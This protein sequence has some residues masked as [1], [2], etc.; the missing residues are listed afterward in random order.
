LL[1]DDWVQR[2]VT[3]NPVGHPSPKT[4]MKWWDRMSQVIWAIWIEDRDIVWRSGIGGHH[5][6]S[7]SLTRGWGRHNAG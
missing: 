2:R 3:H 1:D 5:K 4:E 6:E 7:N